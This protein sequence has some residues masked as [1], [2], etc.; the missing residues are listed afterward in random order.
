MD[1]TTNQEDL[2]ILR[3]LNQNYLSFDEHSNI[4]GYETL[5][6]DDFMASLADFEIYNKEQFLGMIAEPRPFTELNAHDVQIRIL[7]DFALVHARMTYR[8]KIDGRLRYGRY[9]DD[10]QKRNGKWVC[11]AGNVIAENFDTI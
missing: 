2:E 9:T 8:T 4:E 1:T 11:I 7:G 5:L 6:A 3:V 10:Y